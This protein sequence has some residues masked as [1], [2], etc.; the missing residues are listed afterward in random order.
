MRSRRSGARPICDGSCLPSNHPQVRHSAQRNVRPCGRYRVLSAIPAFCVALNVRARTEEGGVVTKVAAM[1]VGYQAIRETFHDPRD[2]R[3]RR[4]ARFSS[5]ISTD[6]SASRK[7]LELSRARAEALCLVEFQIAYEFK[8]RALSPPDGRHVRYGVPQILRSLRAPRGRRLWGAGGLKETGR[9]QL[10][11][12]QGA[13]RCGQDRRSAF[14]P[15]AERSPIE[16]TRFGREEIALDSNDDPPRRAQ[17]KWTRPTGFSADP[18]PGPAMPVIETPTSAG[19]RC[20]S[21]RR[22]RLRDSPR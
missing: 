14:R 10:R 11:R 2:L 18:P 21:A 17:P 15:A 22:H 9:A 19:D 4:A 12:R 1:S 8:S 20:R 6:P 7:P 5:N 13:P 3:S 16:W